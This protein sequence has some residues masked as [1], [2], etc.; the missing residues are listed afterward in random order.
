MARKAP[1]TLQEW[2]DRYEKKASRAYMNYQDTGD[3]R[4]DRQYYECDIIAECI[5]A[6]INERNILQQ[7][8]EKRTRNCEAQCDRL[9]KSEYS[10]SEVF[11]MLHDAIYW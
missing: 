2:L 3:P 11:I 4:Y 8:R 7:E 1:E 9:I 6:K 10:R 5:R